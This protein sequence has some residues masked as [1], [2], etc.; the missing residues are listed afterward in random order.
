MKIQPLTPTPSILEELGDR[1][2][3]IRKQRGM[4]QEALA[5]AAGVGVATVRRIED[6]KDARLGSWL[7][8]LQALGMHAGIEQLVPGNFRS[9]LAEAKEAYRQVGRRAR[10]RARG[11]R[12]NSPGD[13][14]SDSSD[15]FSDDSSGDSSRGGPGSAREPGFVWGDE[16]R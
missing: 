15:D 13:S 8:I 2:A 3:A 14:P 10:R 12:P 7:G 9:P 16:K 11:P 1:L 5:Q 6:G 4:T